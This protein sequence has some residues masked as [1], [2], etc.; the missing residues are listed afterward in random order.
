ML[1]M[2][3]N[4]KVWRHLGWL[5]ILPVI[6]A[7][8][9]G[10]TACSG[11]GQSNPPLLNK[12]KPESATLP[13]VASIAPA[14][15]ASGG[16]DFTLTVIGSNFST[17]SVVLWNGAERPTSFVSNLQLQAAISSSDI[18]TVKSAQ[19]QVSNPA[20]SGLSNALNF[21][22]ENPVPV[23]SAASPI[24][25]LAAGSSFTLTLAGSGF[26]SESVGQWNGTAR[27]T[28]FVNSTE[29]KVSIFAV[30]VAASGTVQLAVVNPTPGGGTSGSLDFSV[31]SVVPHFVYAADPFQDRI[32]ILSANPSTGALQFTNA[33]PAGAGPYAIAVDRSAE[34]AFVPNYWSHNISVYRVDPTTGQLAEIP[35]SP[36]PGGQGPSWV[37]LDPS[38][39][40]V[41]I[42]N[43]GTNDIS[44]YQIDRQTGQLT[45]VPGSPF[46]A[47]VTPWWVAVD[48]LGRFL[49]TTNFNSADVSVHSID[50]ATGSLTE[51]PG[52]PFPAGSYP[53]PVAVA[54]T[55]RYVYIGGNE[56]IQAYQIEDSTGALTPV[57]GS[58]FAPVA[59]YVESLAVDPSGRFLLATLLDPTQV[60]LFSIDPSTGALSLASGVPFTAAADLPIALAMNNS[61]NF[62]FVGENTNG[63]IRTFSVDA[64]AGTMTLTATENSY[65]NPFSLAIVEKPMPTAGTQSSA[66]MS[67]APQS[68]SI[69]PTAP[70]NQP[71]VSERVASLL[72]KCGQDKPCPRL[73]GVRIP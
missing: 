33:V 35:G 72:A 29:L 48:P 61:G 5:C 54:P 9:V 67:L 44:V 71:I 51:V 38:D 36:L 66:R 43:D 22:V 45:E 7:A 56:G 70:G 10:L 64:M 27:P 47:H 34:F 37:V 59:G 26:V 4:R 18:A 13:S 42:P 2:L 15:K 31:E 49:F 50:S 62:A 73:A 30:D 63:D 11:G 24:S 65:G 3:R 28:T 60:L 46:P 57:P 41:F 20:P 14:S 19:V 53:Y 39:R 12:A 6:L 8:I 52:S 1:Q 68:V 21:Q 17:A 55:G 32:S 69:A 23:V 40:F 25:V 58:P 16:P